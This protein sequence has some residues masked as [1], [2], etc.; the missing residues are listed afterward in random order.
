MNEDMGP[1]L[2]REKRK[3]SVKECRINMKKQYS[4]MQGSEDFGSISGFSHY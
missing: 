4:Q 1:V 3:N 2:E